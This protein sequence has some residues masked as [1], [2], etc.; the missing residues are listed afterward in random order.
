[1]RKPSAAWR[2]S[3]A[4]GWWSGPSAR[5]AAFGAWP[6]PTSAWARHSPVDMVGVPH[7]TTTETARTVGAARGVGLFTAEFLDP[8]QEEVHQFFGSQSLP[9]DGRLCGT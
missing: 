3:R 5:S 1:M 7:T 4:V 6:A 2:C 9:L 8:V